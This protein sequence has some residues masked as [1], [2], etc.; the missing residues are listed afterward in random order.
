MFIFQQVYYEKSITGELASGAVKSLTGIQAK[1]WVFL[2]F[3]HWH[4]CGSRITC[5]YLL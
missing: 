3:N 5:L 2:G 4:A 1:Q